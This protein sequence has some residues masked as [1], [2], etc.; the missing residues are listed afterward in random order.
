MRADVQTNSSF[1][2]SPSTTDALNMSKPEHPSCRLPVL[3]LAVN[4]D[5]GHNVPGMIQQLLH[6]CVSNPTQK[7]GVIPRVVI[8][9]SRTLV[10]HLLVRTYPAQHTNILLV[11]AVYTL[12]YCRQL[13]SAS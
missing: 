13:V 9:T 12:Q 11:Q 2:G 8:V 6:W 10:L 3:T 7:A 5:S 1:I 4:V